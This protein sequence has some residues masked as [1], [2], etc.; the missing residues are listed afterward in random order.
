MFWILICLAGVVVVAIA[1]VA[2]GGAVARTRDLLRPAVFEVHD[3]VE[4]IAERLTPDAAARLTEE[5][6]SRVIGWWLD[7][8]DSV[9]LLS[10]HGQEIGGEVASGISADQDTAA[11]YVLERAIT[12]DLDGG[13]SLEALPVVAVLD[14]LAT[15]LTEVGVIG[16]PAPSSE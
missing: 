3:A 6:V 8:F 13:D 12:E 11:E 14:L 15:Y 9:G 1:L 5:D 7:Y 2:V 4:W 16:T 10:K